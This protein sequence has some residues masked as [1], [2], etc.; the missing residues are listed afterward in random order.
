[1]KAFLSEEE[2]EKKKLFE[3]D[4]FGL[5]KTFEVLKNKLLNLIPKESKIHEMIEDLKNFNLSLEDKIKKWEQYFYCNKE[6]LLKLADQI[7]LE[8]KIYAGP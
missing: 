7:V 2:V 8:Y 5:W 4:I 6:F 1:M 3:N